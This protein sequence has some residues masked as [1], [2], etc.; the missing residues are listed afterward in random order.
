MILLSLPYPPTVNHYWRH[1]V[2]GRRQW[3]GRETLACPLAVE[4]TFYPPDRRKRDLD[5][6]PKLEDQGL[7][8]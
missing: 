5:N 2:I 8:W 3:A 6:L 1:I 4:I 7:L